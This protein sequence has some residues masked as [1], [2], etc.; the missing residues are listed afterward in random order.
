[1]SSATKKA[2]KASKLFVSPTKVVRI[3]RK[4]AVVRLFALMKSKSEAGAWSVSRRSISNSYSILECS[5]RKLVR[6]GFNIYGVPFFRLST[7]IFKSV[8]FYSSIGFECK[9]I[10]V[11]LINY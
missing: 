5:C 8:N 10:L 6:R 1:M 4:W 11:Q 7:T 3:M 2:E 9:L